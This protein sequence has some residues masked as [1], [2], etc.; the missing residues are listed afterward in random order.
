MKRYAGAALVLA[1]GSAGTSGSAVAAD[2]ALKAPP[3]AAAPCA[4]CGFYAGVNGG[5]AWFDDGAAIANETNAGVPFISGTW[6]GTGNFG[7]LRG[8]GGFGG[9]QIGYNWQRAQ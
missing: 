8:S 4:W 9:G 5:G 6:P 7:D 2:M 3:A 1:L